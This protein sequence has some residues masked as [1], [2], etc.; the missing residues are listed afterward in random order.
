MYLFFLSIV[1]TTFL[2]TQSSTT[3]RNEIK[4]TSVANI[5][6]SDLSVDLNITLEVHLLI[7][8]LHRILPYDFV[9]INIV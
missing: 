1:Y 6:T 2:D 8:I 7:V 3:T 9:F 5:S 4:T